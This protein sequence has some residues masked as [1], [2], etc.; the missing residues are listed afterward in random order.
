M[1]A[2]SLGL[3]VG[4]CFQLGCGFI[5]QPGLANAPVLGGDTPET[6]VHDA[7][8]NGHDA[9]E[10][11]GFPPGE[12]L[13]GHVPPCGPRK[14][15]PVTAAFLPNPST[16][17]FTAWRGVCANH[18]PGLTGTEMTLTGVSFSPPRDFLCGEAW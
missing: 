3:V 17:S 1:D 11:T 5:F 14:F 8:A 2:L 15:V 10:R 18:G 9:C 16:G 6:R 7:I 13:R 12:V 4:C